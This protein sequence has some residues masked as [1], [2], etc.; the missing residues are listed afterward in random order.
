MIEE[1]KKGGARPGAGRKPLGKVQICCRVS[2]MAEQNLR[3]M[4]AAKKITIG[5]ALDRML[6]YGCMVDE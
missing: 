5:E 1:V 3:A 2:P 6:K 4:A